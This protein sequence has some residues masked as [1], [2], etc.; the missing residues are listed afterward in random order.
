MWLFWNFASGNSPGFDENLIVEDC[1]VIGIQGFEVVVSG[2]VV[3][4]GAVVVEVFVFSDGGN[5]GRRCVFA[6]L[7]PALPLGEM[8]ILGYDL[9][10][11]F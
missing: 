9:V 10:V 8:G 5:C 11:V 4:V 2:R 6:A 7:I 1:L 3:V